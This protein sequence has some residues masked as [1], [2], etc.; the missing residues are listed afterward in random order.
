VVNRL[1]AAVDSFAVVHRLGVWASV[2]VAHGLSCFMACGIFPYQGPTLVPRI[3]RWILIHCVTGKFRPPP[4][5]NIL[6]KLLKRDFI[7]FY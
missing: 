5:R 1:L 4:E 6:I 7:H 2:V 3:G